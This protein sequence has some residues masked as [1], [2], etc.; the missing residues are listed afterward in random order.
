M[1]MWAR[2]PNCE[3]QILPHLCHV[4][5]LLGLITLFFLAIRLSSKL[6]RRSLSKTVVP[7]LMV[8]RHV[9]RFR[10]AFFHLSVGIEVFC[11]AFS[12]SLYLIFWPP[13]CL[14]PWLSWAKKSCFGRRYSSIRATCPHHRSSAFL[15]WVSMPRI[16]V[17]LMIFWFGIWASHPTRRILRRQRRWNC[18][19]FFMWRL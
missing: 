15:R 3:A 2:R 6:R 8:A 4:T 11:D 19:S 18:S 16:C 17:R 13:M 14:F 5:Q 10:T 7:L 12:V 9:T 1:L